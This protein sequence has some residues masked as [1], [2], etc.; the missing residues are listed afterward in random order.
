MPKSEI[1][2]GVKRLQEELSC[3]KAEYK[4]Y[5]LSVISEKAVAVSE[6]SGN[7]V[8]EVPGAE[9]PELIEFANI[10]SSKVKG[11]LVLISG[12][13]GDYKYVISS[14]SV[15]LR[16]IAPDINKSLLGRG[17]G[18]PNMIQ[19]SFKCERSDI[20]KYFNP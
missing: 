3:V 9:I 11:I 13:E 16:D 12:A 8:I 15:N 18:K 7:L 2:D 5:R 10:A 4:E 6:C 1:S 17:G 20:D 14:E 19:G